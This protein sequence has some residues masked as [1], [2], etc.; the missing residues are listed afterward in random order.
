MLGGL[1]LV[2]ILSAAWILCGCATAPGPVGSITPSASQ[3]RATPSTPAGLPATMASIPNSTIVA[4]VPAGFVSFCTRFPDQCTA[5]PNAPT[6]VVL[7]A[8]QWQVLEQVNEDVNHAISPMDDQKHYGRAEYWTIP[9]DGY[10]DCE[11]YALTKRK[12]LMAAGFPAPSLRVALVVT[13]RN[14]RHAVL[15]VASDRG[16]FVLDNL[17]GEIVSWD[18]AGYKWVERQDPTR[19]WGWVALGTSS[20]PTYVASIASQPVSS[21]R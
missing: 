5:P 14:E 19:A 2:T 10:G 13:W 7:G 8:A 3:F 1:K 15:T 6:T 21:V 4:A 17:T 9:A 18:K 20:D 11:D 12:E 16:D